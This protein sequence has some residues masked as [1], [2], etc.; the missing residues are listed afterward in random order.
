MVRIIDRTSV[1]A[2]ALNS[3]LLDVMIQHEHVE[4]VL[5]ELDRVLEHDIS[6]GKVA[7]ED[8]VTPDAE[9]EPEGL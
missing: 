5:P 1:D 8:E 6:L 2:A 9:H 7:V 3:Y 4:F